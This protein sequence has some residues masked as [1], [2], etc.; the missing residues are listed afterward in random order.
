VPELADA[1]TRDMTGLGA[2]DDSPP[3]LVCVLRSTA[4]VESCRP[5][6]A[7]FAKWSMLPRL[8]PGDAVVAG[9]WCGEGRARGDPNRAAVGEEATW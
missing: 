9:A 7:L 2:D 4:S 5:P 8:P 6:L 3:A 1:L